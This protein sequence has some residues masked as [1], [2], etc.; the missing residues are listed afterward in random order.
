LIRED[1]V[2]KD[3]DPK[4]YK[5]QPI[6]SAKGMSIEEFEEEKVSEQ[7]LI[8]ETKT[9]DIKSNLTGQYLAILDFE[10]QCSNT[11]K[12]TVQE[13]IEFPVVIVDVENRK[14]IEDKFHYYIKP[15]VYPKL[16]PFCIEL[17]GIKQEQVDNGILL[18]DALENLD[19]F[20][21]EKGILES[22]FCFVTCGNW[23]LNTCLKKEAKAKNIEVKDYLKRF[24]N[25]KTN[26]PVPS[27]ARVRN[28]DM[29]A[30]L[31]L[32]ELELIGRH[33]SGIDD[34]VNIARVV[35][36]LLEKDFK[37]KMSMTANA[38]Y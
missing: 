17:T 26:Y 33:H 11:E 3:L 22:S 2:L 37:F 32:S 7:K 20:L 16:L 24:I 30:M 35:V 25:L 38:E 29:V 4:E 10:A 13:I 18:Q 5:G 34:A 6:Q 14:I 12:L 23:D 27:L 1:G 28:P 19:Q 9:S 15:V 31:K 8:E 36:Y 21:K